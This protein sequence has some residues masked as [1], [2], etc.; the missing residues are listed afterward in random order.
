LD[1]QR[2]LAPILADGLIATE[3]A[4]RMVQEHRGEYPSLW[5]AIGA[6]ARPRQHPRSHWGHQRFRYA[7]SLRRVV[8]VEMF[9]D[10]RNWP[11][12]FVQMDRRSSSCTCLRIVSVPYACVDRDA[13]DWISRYFFAGSMMPSDDL[14]LHCEDDLRLL[15]LLRP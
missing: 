14:A 3:P 6:P 4:V 10:L 5:A 13:S 9:E 1:V 7:R 12:A 8:S 15:R 11:R 2:Y